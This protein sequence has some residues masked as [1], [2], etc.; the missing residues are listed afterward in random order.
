M[1]FQSSGTSATC[2]TAFALV[3]APSSHFRLV[4]DPE[5]NLTHINLDDPAHSNQF[6]YHPKQ[7]FTLLHQVG[8]VRYQG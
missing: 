8:L 4:L 6:A 7:P 5:K 1:A 2:S 3:A